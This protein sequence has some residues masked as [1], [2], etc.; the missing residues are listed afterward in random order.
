MHWIK[1][2]KT[3]WYKLNKNK[4]VHWSS[5]LSSHPNFLCTTTKT[6]ILMKIWMTLKLAQT[7]LQNKRILLSEKV[8]IIHHSNNNSQSQT[9]VKNAQTQINQWDHSLPDQLTYSR[10][11]HLKRQI[12]IKWLNMCW[13]STFLS[14]KTDWPKHQL[15]SS[16]ARKDC[17]KM[18]IVK[19]RIRSTKGTR[20]LAL[21]SVPWH[22]TLSAIVTQ[23]FTRVSWRRKNY[24]QKNQTTLLTWKSKKT[25][26]D[27]DTW[28]E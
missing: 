15:L 28:R 23:S 27:R 10:W 17:T 5:N 20:Y 2:T 19:T 6:M 16:Q 3:R 14:H 13:N 7:T 4:V 18:R 22:E 25:G 26:R 24:C 21:I 11:V 1:W 9:L 8:T 12:K